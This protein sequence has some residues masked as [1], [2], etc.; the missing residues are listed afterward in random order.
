MQNEIQ[1]FTNE[2]F[3]SVRTHADY[4]NQG[5]RKLRTPGGMITENGLCSAVHQ[6]G[7]CFLCRSF[8]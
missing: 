2:K 3:G 7:R 4:R 6:I 5:V 8:G 1:V